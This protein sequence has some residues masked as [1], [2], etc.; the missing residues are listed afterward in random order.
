MGIASRSVS[1]R[2]TL[3]RINLGDAIF[4]GWAWLMAATLVFIIALLVF[5][6]YEGSKLGISRFGFGF[7]FEERWD[8]VFEHFGSLP[9]IFGTV[10]SSLLSLAIAA[11]LGLMAAIFLA[12][13]APSWLDQSLSFIIELLASVPSVVFGLWGLYVLVPILRDPIQRTLYRSLGFLPVFGCTPLGIGMMAAVAVL[14]IMILPYA[15]AVARDML[16][17]V[18]NEQ[19][20]AMLALGATRWETIWRAVVPYARS[21]IIGGFMLALGRAVGETMAVTMLIGNRPDISP[22]LFSPAYTL[23]SQ[24][25][26]EFTESVSP[27]HVS[28]LIELGLVLFVITLILNGLARLL[29]WRIGRG[30]MRGAR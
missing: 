26:N 18:P 15:T 24:I 2:A 6:L 29:V 19:R 27:L 5:E 9:A 14:A 25:A 8:P 21:G 10:V 23:A 11:P 3:G 1:R 17:A 16:R 12:E 13:M 30:E 22:C 4:G 20:E 28:V 7:L